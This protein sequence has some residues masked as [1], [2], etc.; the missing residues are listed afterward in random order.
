M[1][2]ATVGLRTEGST[3]V[4]CLVKH[5]SWSRDDPQGLDLEGSW[6]ECRRMVRCGLW[7]VWMAQW[8]RMKQE[9]RL[10]D[11]GISVESGNG[12]Q[13]CRT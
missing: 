1:Q 12:C 4:H 11:M 9:T 13:M 6:I 3:S 7:H 5:Y 10:I 2:A 8:W